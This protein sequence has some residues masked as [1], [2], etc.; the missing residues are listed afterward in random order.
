MTNLLETA[1]AKVAAL[2]PAAQ[3]KIGEELI[4][5]VEKMER[6]RAG[7]H[8]GVRS[9]QRG[10]GKELDMSNVIKRARAEHGKR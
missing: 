2:P 1:M 6:L 3:E 8:K 9:L 7:L 5:H 10:E 4:A